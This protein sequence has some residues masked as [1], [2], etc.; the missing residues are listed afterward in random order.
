MRRPGDPAVVAG[1]LGSD[2]AFV[3]A[4]GSPPALPTRRMADTN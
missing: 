2:D 4:M 1:Y 3:D